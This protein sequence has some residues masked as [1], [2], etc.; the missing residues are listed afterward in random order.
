VTK[1]LIVDDEKPIREAVRAILKYE[2][3]ATVEA[4]DGKAAVK[5]V[6]DDPEIGCVLCDVK[7][8][9]MDGVECL[10]K[11]KALRPEL[12]VVMISGH[13][14]IET[15]VEAAKKGAFD[16]LEKPPDRDRLLLV[17]RNATGATALRRENV[18]LK[19]ELGIKWRLLG[20]SQGIAQVR[21][22]IE[23]VAASDARVLVLGEHGTGKEL[24]ARNVHLLSARASGPFVD[25]NCAAIPK[26]LIESELF[27]HEKGAF[28]G[29]DA[30][31]IGKFEEAQGGTLFL[32]EIGDMD[33]AAQ[34]KLLRVLEEN[35]V[36]RVGGQGTVAVDVRVVAATNKD[37]EALSKEGKFRED[38]Y[39]RLAVIPI[40]VPPLRDRSEDVPD[41]F[42][43]FFADYAAKY[44]R[45][46]LR[47]DA[48]ALQDLKRRPW[49][50]NVRELRNFAERAAL[51]CQGDVL[52]VAATRALGV[53]APTEAS[54][55]F[56]IENFEQF[57]DAAEKAYLLKKLEENGWNIKRTAERLGMQRSN[58]YKKIDRYNLRDAA[59]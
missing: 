45:P 18:R 55:L 52:D 54:D 51:L 43:K 44:G 3:M 12:P 25:V 2:G 14:T 49:P 7:M 33:L 39:F 26:E 15:A 20:A 22:V 38:L 27:G 24:V 57:Q 50:G 56:A 37:L 5:A 48:E 46:N 8:P 53:A 35:K 11:I 34:A 28:T 1:V 31:K 42:L 6:G 36:Q 19:G 30:R 23:R 10:E 47:A 41:L 21:S 29:A 13:G 16:F 9:G 32:D 17:L 40:R 59:D 4:S 58:M